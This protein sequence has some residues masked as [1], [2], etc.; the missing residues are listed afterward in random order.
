LN[1]VGEER[2]ILPT[3]I[4]RKANWNDHILSR[5]YLLKLVVEGKIERGIEVTGRRGR[6]VSR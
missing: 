3:I 5:N 2:S 1:R 4:R 6:R